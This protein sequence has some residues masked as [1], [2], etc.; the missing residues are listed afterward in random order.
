MYYISLERSLNSGSDHLYCVEIQTEMAEKSQVKYHGFYMDLST[1]SIKIPQ[2]G[3]HPV[4]YN[5]NNQ[6]FPQI[7]KGKDGCHFELQKHYQF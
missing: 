4:Y 1:M 6:S 5:S 7:F 2:I 3:K